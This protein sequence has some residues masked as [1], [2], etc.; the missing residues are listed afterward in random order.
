MAIKKYISPKDNKEYFKVRVVRK[1]K[2]PITG[3]PVT[4]EKNANGIKTK[5]EAEKIE[6]KLFLEAERASFA[7]VT[8]PKWG[9]LVTEWHEAV[10]RGDVF[11]RSILPSTADD[12]LSIL[13]EHTHIWD[14]LSIEDI[15][16]TKAW[17]LL[18]HVEKTVSIVRR[19]KVR[20][21]VDT[22]F[23][24][25]A[26]AGH[27][28][29]IR[30]LPTEGYKSNLREEEKLP[31]ILTLDQIKHLLKSAKVLAHPW[32]EIWA[33]ALMTGMR[34]GELYA[35][36]WPAIDLENRMI[37]VH[38]NWTNKNGFGPTK[39]RY[40]RAV[41]MN[42]AT[43]KFFQELK[44]NCPP[45]QMSVLPRFQDWTDGEQA[46][47]LRT[48]CGGIGVPSVK[49]HTLRACFATQLIKDGVA[50]AV[51]M[52]L[53]GWKDLKT[54]QRYIRLA[55]IEVKGATETLNILPDTEVMGKVYELFSP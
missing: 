36:E 1:T 49:F 31:E 24:W 23:R 55:G 32:Y 38:R 2:H 13:R 44:L 53:C 21:C 33:V 20:T 9:K 11:V 28:K 47:V 4:V 51:I 16:K 8:G 46:A 42:E 41:P 19:K 40:W 29:D 5:A 45:E 18:E 48:F 14:H 43:E 26:L 7:V 22:V 34:S 30:N 12:Y 3:N 27:V 50:P 10:W 52:K 15:D 54:M 6:K 35:L 17:T 37:Y 25:A 39:G